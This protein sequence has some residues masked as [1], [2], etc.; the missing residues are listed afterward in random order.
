[1]LALSLVVKYAVNSMSPVF[2]A[3][4]IAGCLFVI[5]VWTMV[6]YLDRK[7]GRYRSG[8]DIGLQ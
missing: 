7:D 3:G 8:P 6:H 4:F 5:A 1:M 2:L